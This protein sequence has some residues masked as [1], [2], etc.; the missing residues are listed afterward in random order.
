MGPYEW[1]T[2]ALEALGVVVTVVMLV[3]DWPPRKGKPRKPD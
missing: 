1:L 3:I 2:V